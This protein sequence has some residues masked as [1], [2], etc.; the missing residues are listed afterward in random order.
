[1]MRK[2]PGRG[3]LIAA[4]LAALLATGLHPAAQA[5][6]GSRYFPETGHTV[7]GPF[8]TY[9][10]QHGG[11]AQQGLPLTEEAPEVSP[12]DGKTYTMQYFERAVFELHPEN[13]PPYN[14]LL[15]RLGAFRY[16]Q[17]YPQ[18]A[19]N[20]Q[21]SRDN[22][23]RFPETG[24]TIGGAFRAYW[25]QHGGLAQQGFPISE[26]FQEQSD[27]DG[28]TYTVQYFERAVFERHP[29]NKPPYDVLLAQ[30]GRFHLAIAR[31][32]DVAS[33]QGSPPRIYVVKGN[34]TQLW[35]SD[36]GSVV[37]QY[38]TCGIQPQQDP[39]GPSTN[40]CEAPMTLTT[41]ITATDGGLDVTFSSTWEN[42]ARRHAWR[43]HV[44]GDTQATFVQESGD[45]LPIL[46]Q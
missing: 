6:T 37:T 9:W 36:T 34:D 43:L 22:P 21:P 16:A 27:L 42:G 33:R 17:R 4:A 30:L 41:A 35:P 39:G 11:V 45:R 44:S 13:Q 10:Q 32:R 28:K 2:H 23:L 7:K 31:A 26:E 1:M 3:L 19:P 29:E 8:L 18:G 24:R 46:P 25:E 38:S 15:S 14:V 12:V 40:P 5:Q 20:Q